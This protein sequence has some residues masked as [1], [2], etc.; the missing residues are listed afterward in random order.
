M[1][2]YSNKIH[3][4]VKQKAFNTYKFSS[5]IRSVQFTPA[6]IEAPPNSIDSAQKYP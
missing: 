1:I 2:Y 3:S 6:T 5:S 4:Q